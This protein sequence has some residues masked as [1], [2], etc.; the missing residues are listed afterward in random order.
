[1]KR[2]LNANFLGTVA[3]MGA[4]VASV[5]AAVVSAEDKVEPA[6][7]QN[8]MAS[9]LLARI[10]VQGEKMRRFEKEMFIYAA[11]PASRAKYVKE[12]DEAHVKLL[13]LLTEASMPSAKSFSDEERQQIKGWAEATAFYTAEF[14]KIATA[15]E[16][17]GRQS[18]SPEDRAALTIKFNGDI[19]EGKDRFA[20]LLN[21]AAKLREAKEQASLVINTEID[22]VFRTLM[23]LVAGVAALAIVG[24]A[25]IL[26]SASGASAV[27]PAARRSQIGPLSVG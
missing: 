15:A 6:I 24:A 9:G 26:P 7:R 14:L 21:G 2:L 4:L 17:L 19:K 13:A 22:S 3:L 20:A 5:M 18:T 8:F 27:R 10:Q 25:Y 16:T 23:L 12:F 1:M 11:V